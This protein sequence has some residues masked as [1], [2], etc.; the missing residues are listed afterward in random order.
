MEESEYIPLK[1]IRKSC[2]IYLK[3]PGVPIMSHHV[4][5][6]TSIHEDAGSIPDHAQ[7]LKGSSI[8]ANCGSD[9]VLLWLWGRPV[10]WP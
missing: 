10:A 2:Q 7:W 8:A 9:V 1:E 5:N 3:F 6:P 4:R